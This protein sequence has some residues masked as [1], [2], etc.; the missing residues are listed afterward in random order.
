MT[1]TDLAAWVDLAQATVIPLLAYT[2]HALLRLVRSLSRLE[3]QQE[4]LA[5]RIATVERQLWALHSRG[6]PP[7]EDVHEGEG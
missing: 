2:A 4:A 6:F 5:A 7:R 1:L 3:T